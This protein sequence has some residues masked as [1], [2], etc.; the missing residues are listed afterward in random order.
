MQKSIKAYRRGYMQAIK[1]VEQL[2]SNCEENFGDYS[3]APWVYIYELKDQLIVL[4]D[5][6][7]DEDCRKVHQ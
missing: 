4:E 3:K 5:D 2:L 6:F 7:T 1:D